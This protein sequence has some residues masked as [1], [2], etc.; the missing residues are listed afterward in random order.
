MK[1]YHNPRCSKSREALSLIQAAGVEP[2]IV[3][4]L[5]TPPTA[6]E[7]NELLKALALRPRDIIR[8]KE[9]SFAAL[10]LNLDDDAAVLAALVKH[11]E[12]LE[13]PIVIQGSKAVVARPPEKLRD[14]F[15]TEE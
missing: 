8:T 9:E 12:L 6:T 2:E 3:D 11:P 7:L 13:R 15:K 4:Y 5:K 1:I 14:L 10:S